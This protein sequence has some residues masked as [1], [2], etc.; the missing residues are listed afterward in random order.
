MRF[1]VRHWAQ[2][3]TFRE[4]QRTDYA[5]PLHR[6]P[7][8][9]RDNRP[10]ECGALWKMAQLGTCARATARQAAGGLRQVIP[11]PREVRTTTAHYHC[12]LPLRTIVIASKHPKKG[13]RP[14]TAG[15]PKVICQLALT[16]VLRCCA[17]PVPLRQPFCQ[18]YPYIWSWQ[19]R[20]MTS[21]CCSRVRSMNFT[22]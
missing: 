15:A 7:E 22:A 21:S 19:V 14:V 3:A 6:R 8:G 1:S 9:A 16:T 12:A 13:T 17:S 11:S 10:P 5:F 4:A 2:T 18:N 20:A